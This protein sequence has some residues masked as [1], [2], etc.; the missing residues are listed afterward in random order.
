MEWLAHAAGVTTAGAAVALVLWPLIQQR[1]NRVWAPRKDVEAMETKQN[2]LAAQV[3]DHGDEIGEI[4]ATN[5]A[6]DLQIQH[7]SEMVAASI[8]EPLR[9]ISKRLEEMQGTQSKMLL[10]QATHTAEM[11]ALGRGLDD[12][13]NRLNER[14]GRRPPT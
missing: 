9:G 2:A 10:T 12:M 4:K 13:K 3:D 14:E 5:Q 8:V 6:Q 1:G 11:R 7:Q